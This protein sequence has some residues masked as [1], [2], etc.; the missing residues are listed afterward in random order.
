LLGAGDGLAWELEQIPRLRLQGKT[1]YILP[2]VEPQAVRA[3]LERSAEDGVSRTDLPASTQ[4]IAY[5]T[6]DDGRRTVVAASRPVAQDYE[7]A[8]RLA[9]RDLGLV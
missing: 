7:C 8:I 1:I 9:A 5:W 2:P 3:I 6:L 4:V